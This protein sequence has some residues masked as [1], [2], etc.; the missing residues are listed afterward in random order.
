MTLSRILARP[1][2]TSIFVVGPVKTLQD[3]KPA[4][5]RA[6]KVTRRVVAALR[7]AGLQV[8]EDPLF[9]V[10]LNAGVQLAAAAGLATGKMPRLSAAVLAGSLVPTTLAGHD[11]WNEPDPSVRHQQ[12]IHWAKNVSL[13]GGLI[14]AARDT[15][16]RPGAAWL[17]KHALHDAQRE[18]SHA[19]STAKLEARIAALDAGLGAGAVTTAL[20]AAGKQA[21]TKVKDK[22]H[23]AATSDTAHQLADR[24]GVL[25]T[26]AREQ[27][28]VVAASA[29]DHLASFAE[30]AREEAR[31]VVKDLRK[32][33]ERKAKDLRKQARATA[34]DA[35]KAYRQQKKV[36]KT[37][38]GE[39]RER[40]A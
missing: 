7:K 16:G 15:D 14:I 39:L 18:A 28:P 17:A 36:T 29:R 23:E 21:G 30:T 8:P 19:A 24:A 35:R 2:L 4:A 33:G 27:A 25:A 22:L 12:L 31:P 6:D 32:Q 38:I 5:E 26:A 34:K 40:L 9:W 20:A 3:P 10:R 37:Q 1:M 11:F 13:L